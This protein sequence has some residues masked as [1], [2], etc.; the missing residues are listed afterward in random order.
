V[1]KMYQIL[2]LKDRVRVPPELFTSDIKESIDAAIKKDYE[3]V[4]S[5]KQGFFIS[6][7]SIENIGEGSILPGDGAVYYDVSFEILAYK[8]ELQE[9]VEG[10]VTEITEFGCFVNMGPIAGLSHISQVMDDFVSY[11]KT[12]SLQGKKSKKSIKVGDLVRARIV[13]VSL[14]TL[15]TSKIGLTMRQPGLGKIEWIIEEME[16][17]ASEKKAVKKNE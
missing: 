5:K 6:L 10:E 14:K 8:P 15:Q 17:R 3:G 4:L 12:G 9:I 13:A 7:I 11:S 2:K 16:K 1:I